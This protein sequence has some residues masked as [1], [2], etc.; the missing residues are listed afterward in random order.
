[1]Y[2]LT[3]MYIFVSPAYLCLFYAICQP[4]RP[5][6]YIFPTISH[7]LPIEFYNPLSLKVEQSLCSII[8]TEWSM[9]TEGSG[10]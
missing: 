1:M 4:V 2:I 5:G 6:G 3:Y 10:F 8:K 9:K 7:W